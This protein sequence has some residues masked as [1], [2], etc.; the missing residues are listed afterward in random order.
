MRH[1]R[2]ETEL[3]VELP[4]QIAADSPAGAGQPT[5]QE[6]RG[7]I[8]VLVAGEPADQDIGGESP[9]Q[10]GQGIDLGAVNV[11]SLFRCGGSRRE[12]GPSKQ[13]ERGGI[14]AAS[15]SPSVDFRSLVA[16]AAVG[17]GLVGVGQKGRISRGLDVLVS[18]L[19]P[20]RVEFVLVR[21]NG[22]VVVHDNLPLEWLTR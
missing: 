18:R 7:I 3:R 6:L 9:R 12:L 20:E 16:A 10:A 13:K 5:V 15:S 11:A 4:A 21:L 1:R 19:V 17:R 22:L 8:E 2:V 14:A